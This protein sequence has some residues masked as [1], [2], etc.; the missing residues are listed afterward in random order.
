MMDPA[1]IQ[2]LGFTPAPSEI[3]RRMLCLMIAPKGFG[4]TSMALGGYDSLLNPIVVE[5][6]VFYYKLETGDEGIIEKFKAAGTEV[7]IYRAYYNRTNWTEAWTAFTWC[8]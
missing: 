4:K 5:G 2:G 8:C 1:V 7:Y 6:P 3:R